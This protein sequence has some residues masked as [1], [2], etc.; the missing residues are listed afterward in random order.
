MRL[1]IICILLSV[2]SLIIAKPLISLPLDSDFTYV[3]TVEGDTESFDGH[4]TIQEPHFAL[5]EIADK[6][7]LV[8]NDKGTWYYDHELEEAVHQLKGASIPV[9]T[10]LM[11]GKLPKG[12][13]HKNH[14]T[15]K[16]NGEVRIKDQYEFDDDAMA[17]TATIVLDQD[18]HLIELEYVDSFEVQH[19]YHLHKHTNTQHKPSYFHLNVPEGMTITEVG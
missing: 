10:W 7:T 1:C 3:Q 6:M 17:V 11:T 18:G 2:H 5:Y 14:S 9:F 13:S 15:Y 16:K 19:H 4:L 12:A 8:M